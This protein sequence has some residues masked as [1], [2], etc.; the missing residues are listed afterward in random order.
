LVGPWLE[1]VAEGIYRVSPLLR[2]VG[3]AV[4]G[5]AW[6]TAMH[7]GIA[8]AVLALRTLSPSDVST[9]LFHAIAGR[10]WSPVTHLSIGLLRSDNE[11]W[12]ALAQSAD[13]FVLV[14]TG[15][16]MRPETDVFSLSFIRLLQFRLAAA[17]HDDRG[18]ASVIACIEE[19]L[20]ATV[21][22]IPLRL[23][24]H[25]FLGQVLLCAGANLPM[26]QIV[27]TGLE[28]M[29]LTNEMKDVLAGVEE[30]ELTRTMVGPD[31]VHNLAGIAG[32]MLMQHLTDRHCLAAL[33]AAC[34]PVDPEEVR[35]LLW[36]VGGQGIHCADYF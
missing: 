34:E 33:L 12:E 24:R 29:R 20:P 7:S 9:I 32:F 2:G 3:P 36:F 17:G 8:H 25:F 35:R 11:T 27:S 19:E 10:D 21:E 18:A 14:G 26:A 6:A 1:T 13:W 22:S 4:Q 30:P 31:G 28:Y 5:E 16:A 23:M 15:S